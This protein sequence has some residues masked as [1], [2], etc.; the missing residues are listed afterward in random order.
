MTMKVKIIVLSVLALCFLS[1][2]SIAQEVE[3]LGAGATF[4]YPL[5]S[6]MFDVYNKE[7][8]VKINYQAI[9]SGGGI[10]QVKNK[11][12]DFGGTDA[13]VKDK[14]MKDMPGHIVHIP[15]CLGAVA[16]TYNLP[17]KP[18]LKISSD[19]I[20]G[21]FTGKITNWNDESIKKLNPGINL[22]DMKIVVV[23]RSDGSGT[24]SCLVIA[25][26]DEL[27]PR[28]NIGLAHCLLVATNS[29]LPGEGIR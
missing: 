15:I 7:Y 10:R 8:N 16:V 27:R 3:L 23:H 26:D 24:T 28:G 6:K 2:S 13:F 14:D 17:G 12:V 11:T 1:S 4:P 25:I 5:Y 22:P 29:L 21:I 9:G 18:Q 20:A 19:I